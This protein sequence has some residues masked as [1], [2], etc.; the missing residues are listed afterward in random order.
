MK[1]PKNIFKKKESGSPMSFYASAELKKKIKTQTKT[2]GAKS[3]SAYLARLL[4][5]VLDEEK[6]K[7]G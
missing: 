7:K 4:E 3:T 2:T 1:V 6:E 5:F